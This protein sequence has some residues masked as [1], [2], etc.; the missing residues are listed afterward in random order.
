LEVAE[1][2]GVTADTPGKSRLQSRGGY[3]AAAAGLGIT[4]PVA[5][6]QM[7][8]LPTNTTGQCAADQT[9]DSESPAAGHGRDED[10]AE[11]DHEADR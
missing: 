6:C 10:E 4:D 8:R 9:L 1:G 7:V 5:V 2:L 11:R 3:F